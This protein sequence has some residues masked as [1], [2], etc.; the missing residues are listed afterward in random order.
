MPEQLEPEQLEPEQLEPEQLEPPQLE[1]EHPAEFAPACVSAPNPGNG[2]GRVSEANNS[3]SRA[4]PEYSST[5]SASEAPRR[6]SVSTTFELMSICQH[7]T[8]EH[9]FEASNLVENVADPLA[10]GSLERSVKLTVGSRTHKE[11]IMGAVI[12]AVGAG[13]IGVAVVFVSLFSVLTRHSGVSRRADSVQQ[14][15]PQLAEELRKLQNDIDR[16]NGRRVFY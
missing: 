1:H 9:A 12:A 11:L 7:Y 13:L 2:A 3:S 16:G 14:S 6:E 4:I 5:S 10:H 15:D 8:I